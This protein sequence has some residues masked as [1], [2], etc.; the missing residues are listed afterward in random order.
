MIS[1]NRRDDVYVDV[2]TMGYNMAGAAC[3]YELGS[4]Y[5]NYL[6]VGRRE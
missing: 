4:N 6:V 5:L 2:C 3:R 1:S